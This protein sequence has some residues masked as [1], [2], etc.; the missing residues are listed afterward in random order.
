MSGMDGRVQTCVGSWTRLLWLDQPVMISP[1]RGR[2]ADEVQ[3][4]RSRCGS[5]PLKLHL[6]PRSPPPLQIQSSRN[7]IPTFPPGNQIILSHAGESPE[8]FRQTVSSLRRPSSPARMRM[9]TST[10]G[11]L[12][13][14]PSSHHSFVRRSVGGAVVAVDAMSSSARRQTQKRP[15]PI[16]TRRHHHGNQQEEAGLPL[17]FWK[18]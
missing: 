17:R 11:L 1:G 5:C 4:N 10:A 18:V 15:K 12:H 13:P 7:L 16:R 6:D 2:A 8:K 14:S 3:K 9:R